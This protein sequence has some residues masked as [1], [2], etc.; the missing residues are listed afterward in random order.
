[1][2]EYGL[3][4]ENLFQILLDS[5]YPS[6]LNACNTNTLFHSICQD[7]YLWE[8][9]ALLDFNIS[10]DTFRNSNL[11][12]RQRYHQIYTQYVYLRQ[13]LLNLFEFGMYIRQWRGPG[14][15]YPLLARDTTL[16]IRQ[17]TYNQQETLIYNSLVQLVESYLN[18]PDRIK[19]S[20]KNLNT[21]TYQD[22]QYI[23][24]GRKIQD[25]VDHIIGGQ[26]C[27]RIYSSNIITTAVYYLQSL[28]GISPVDVLQLEAIA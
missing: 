3:P 4:I 7:P 21:V 25:I 5:D 1:M 19:D 18:A 22:N 17:G 26:G 23:I 16:C 10:L 6:I 12:G 28:F 27:M 24:G 14:T 2:D 11:T 20:I 15:P 8:Q 9:K 13:Y